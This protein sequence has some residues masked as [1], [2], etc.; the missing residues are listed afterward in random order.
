MLA[1]YGNDDIDLGG[2]YESFKS[3]DIRTN[4]EW[5]NVQT[6]SPREICRG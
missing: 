1:S 6:M 5:H 3:F 4:G 2:G